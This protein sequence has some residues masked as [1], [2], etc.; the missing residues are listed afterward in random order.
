MMSAGAGNRETDAR[1][2][3]R[4]SSIRR[5]AG[6]GIALA[7]LAAVVGA[8]LGLGGVAGFGVAPAAAEDGA[9]ATAS[10]VTVKWAGGNDTAVQ[11]FQPDHAALTSDG[12]GTDNGSGHWDDFKD[13][14]VTVSKTADLREEAVVVSAKG[15]GTSN[16][17][18]NG[19]AS[20]FLQLMQCWGPDPSA[21][22]F[23]QTCQYGA[24]SGAA[25]SSGTVLGS[26]LGT[27][28][29][30]RAGENL[31]SDPSR[32][33][34]VTGDASVQTT[35]TGSGSTPVTITTDG[36]A[37]FFG[38][39]TSNEQPFVA[40][41]SDGTARTGFEVQ[42]AL[43]QPYLGCGKAADLQGAGE[44]CWLVVVPRGT[45]SNALAADKPCTTGGAFYPVPWGKQG[46]NGVQSG[47]PVDPACAAWQDRI[48]VPL[49]FASTAPSCPPGAMERRVSGTELLATAFSSWQGALCGSG[50][51][52]LSFNTNSGDLN[53][54]QL[55]T[56]QS[57][58]VVVG[59]PLT[60][61][62]I[63]LADP[64]LLNS[65][66]LRYAPVAN[67]ALAI[68][69]RWQSAADKP[70]TSREM[71]LTPRLLA[72]V[73]TMSYKFEVPAYQ[74]SFPDNVDQYWPNR[75]LSMCDDPE[76]VALGNPAPGSPG[77]CRGLFLVVGPQSDDVTALLW[78]Y[79]RSDA[80]A[81]AF[82]RGEPDP[83][84]NTINPY[85][86]PASN[87]Q[88]R[89]GGLRDIDLA[90]QPMDRFLRADRTVA[91]DYTLRGELVEQTH[92]ETYDAVSQIPFSESFAGNTSRI[93]RGDTKRIDSW[94]TN[95]VTG[96]QVVPGWVTVD[97]GSGRFGYR[98]FGPAD[99]GAAHRY[100]L[101][102][103]SLGAPRAERTDEST[104]VSAR[105]F[106]APTAASMAA[107]LAA[108]HTDPA[109]GTA[110]ADFGAFPEDGY[111]LT[112]T[113]YAAVDVTQAKL[114]EAA[115]SSYAG[116]LDYAAGAGQVPGTAPGQLPDSYVP[117][118]DSQRQQTSA[119]AEQLRHPP[120]KDGAGPAA[121]APAAARPAGAAPAAAAPAAN[122]PA[123]RTGVTATGVTP[124]TNTDAVSAAS[125]TA[126]GGTLVA[127]IAGLVASP[128]LLR[129]RG[130]G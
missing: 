118:S 113:L 38:P 52:T 67:T 107:A 65:A 63:G 13:L 15:M 2:G 61:G 33:L 73:M 32:F 114:D 20:N 97:P 120:T 12:N 42:S 68:A 72:K 57:S 89:D 69:F 110:T 18:T 121:V 92:G 28:V 123:T 112:T 3:A 105:S 83:W 124:A 90:T 64:A 44:R 71:K 85:Y 26:A 66:T 19:V 30:S 130:I 126:L 70:A 41:G 39:S 96:G 43:S 14:E 125:Q 87:P 98:A 37:R 75:P 128:F 84:G 109:T 82:L 55:L 58:M 23:N 49:D 91:P 34:A 29:V 7:S 117:L 74:Y 53:R 116:F 80:D 17:P 21:A 47:S 35:V 40:I 108:Q 60:P 129:R 77:E 127:G 24:Y 50:T 111:P 95:R 8:M 93:F 100:G 56:G 88:A 51:G 1:R 5:L 102:L 25:S 81:A 46:W 11:R 79:L 94:S 27:S 122:T 48:V 6:R 76:W 78:Q 103:A 101:A 4:R 10:A 119:V 9:G 31:F 45:H 54:A 22:D 59:R 16:L 62:T 86:L 36:T 99:L 104:V 115:R 106:V